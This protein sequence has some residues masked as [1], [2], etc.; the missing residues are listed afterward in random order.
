[1]SFFPFL[2]SQATRLCCRCGVAASRREFFKVAAAAVGATGLAGF[3]SPLEAGPV[4]DRSYP[5]PQPAVS[6][7]A[8]LID[9]HC[10]TGP[11]VVSRSADDDEALELYHDKG[12]EAVVF[13]NHH[14]ITADRATLARK[15]VPE[16]KVF[17]GIVLNY[18]VGGINPDAVEWMWRMQGG[19]GRMVW[20]PTSDANN[21]VKHA[22]PNAPEGIKVLDGEGKM[23]PAVY[24]VLKVCA[25]QKLIVNTGHLSAEEGLAVIAAARDVG[26]DRIIV[27]HAQSEWPNLSLEQMKK[28]TAMGAKLELIAQGPLMGPG[29]HGPEKALRNIPIRETVEAI[30]A[31]GAEHFVLGTDLGQITNPTHADG[32]QMFV[33]DLM[34]QG[35]S[36]DQIKQMG[37]EVPGALLMG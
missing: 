4:Q 9:T 36:L 15:H 10:H 11:D 16:I 23:L 19:Y 21:N 8:G 5:H 12:M 22:N 31:L 17:G 30:Q 25:R 37:R 29:A 7:I 28:A 26:V 18:S 6:V 1:M 33:T 20:F 27:T 34:A 32:L 24:D 14:V 3:S 13:K 35:I 2:R